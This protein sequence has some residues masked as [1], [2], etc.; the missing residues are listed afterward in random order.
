MSLIPNEMFCKLCNVQFMTIL[1]L[2]FFTLII[3]IYLHLGQNKGKFFN[4]VSSLICTPVLFPQIGQRTYC[5]LCSAQIPSGPM[6]PTQTNIINVIII[7]T[8][9]FLSIR[10]LS[11]L[12]FYFLYLNKKPITHISVG[13]GLSAL[14]LCVWLFD[15]YIVPDL[16]PRFVST[17]RAAYKFC[18]HKAKCHSL[19]C[20]LS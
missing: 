16:H 19:F 15:L 11:L 6:H 14:R 7:V 8:L 12:S 10:L 17:N 4:S 13:Y 5:I 2:N 20:F 3:V 18:L 1:A 9:S